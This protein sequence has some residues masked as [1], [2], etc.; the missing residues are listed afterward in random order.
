[1]QAQ[2]PQEQPLQQPEQ[3]ALPQQAQPPQV[4]LSPPEPRP[5]A[6]AQP[7]PSRPQPDAQSPAQL[8][9]CWQSPEPVQAPQYLLPAWVEVRSAAEPLAQP[10]Q[11]TQPPEQPKPQPVPQSPPLP[12]RL[13]RVNLLHAKG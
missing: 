1:V 2:P 9:A 8:V 10:P 4:L 6:S 5:L 12:S 7:E 13:L 11:E 3:Q